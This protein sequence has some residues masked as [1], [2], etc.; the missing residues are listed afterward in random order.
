MKSNY[1]VLWDLDGTLIDS[2]DYHF[3][4]WQETVEK[5]GYALSRE[6]FISCFGQRSETAVYTYCNKNL[7]LSDAQRI[8]INKQLSYREIIRTKGI[9]LVPNAKNLLLELKLNKWQQ[10]LATSASAEDVETILRVLDLKDH[11]DAWVSAEAVKESKPSPE[12]FL[13]AADRLKIKPQNCIVVEDSAVGIE[14]AK[15]AKM[16]SIGVLSSH[17]NLDADLIVHNLLEITIDI[18]DRLIKE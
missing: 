3:K 4:A 1:A 13:L 17:K 6:T 15:R 14:A 18:F 2:T 9:E 12:I 8:V 16:K 10:A 7:T 11:F 5:E